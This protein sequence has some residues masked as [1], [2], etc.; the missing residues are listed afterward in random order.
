MSTPSQNE[1]EATKIRPKSNWDPFPSGSPLKRCSISFLEPL[2]CAMTS[3]PSSTD[4]CCLST[5]AICCTA[6]KVVVNTKVRPFKIRAHAKTFKASCCAC[7][8][9]EGAGKSSG[10]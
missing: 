1:A 4:N 7:M 8:G 9:S 2:P 5:W 3:N 10:T 6:R